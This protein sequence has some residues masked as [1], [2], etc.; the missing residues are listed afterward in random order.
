MSGT[1]QSGRSP[2]RLTPITGTEPIAQDDKGQGFRP[3]MYF[4]QL[5]QRLL[6]YIGQPTS[7]NTPGV[8]L[9]GQVGTLNSEMGFVLSGLGPADA[10]INARVAELEVKSQRLQQLQPPAVAT[11]SDAA[12][13]PAPPLPVAVPSLVDTPRPPVVIERSPVAPLPPGD[14][15][16]LHNGGR[17][18]DGYGSPEG[19]VAGGIGDLYLRLDGADGTSAYLKSSGAFGST[20]G[21]SAIGGGTSII[22]APLVNGDLPGPTLIANG[23]GECI[24]V[25][26][27]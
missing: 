15:L 1:G 14:I 27:T 19:N 3:T 13:F 23:A 10:G 11:R 21:W 4:L 20:T 17:V 5:I 6:S 22:Y 2:T 8:T 26:I 24:M 18:L 16:N 9:S 7:S 25:P 12:A